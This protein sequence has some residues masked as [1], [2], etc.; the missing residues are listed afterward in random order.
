M[1]LVLARCPPL[2]YAS[3][4]LQGPRLQIGSIESDA[5][6]SVDAIQAPAIFA[7]GVLLYAHGGSL[8]GQGF[9]ASARALRGEPFVV[10]ESI[11]VQATTFYAFFS[12]STAAVLAYRTA[13]GQPLSQLTWLDR[14]GKTVA[15]AG[16][17]ARFVNVGLS[18]DGRRAAAARGA[19][20]DRPRMSTSGRRR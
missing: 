4:T 9:D 17:P 18:G 6:E 20:T 2:L 16:E 3:V 19:P 1:A 12:A 11:A 14:L 15:T 5:T 10:T 8:V 13:Q 7:G